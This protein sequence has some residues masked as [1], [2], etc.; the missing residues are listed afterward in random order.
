MSRCVWIECRKP[1]PE[2]DKP[3]RPRKFCDDLCKERDRY[4]RV[5][6]KSD[7]KP[8]QYRQKSAP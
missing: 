7:R 1:L 4:A 8:D 3:G 6:G 5:S 2:S